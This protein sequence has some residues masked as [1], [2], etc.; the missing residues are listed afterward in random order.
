MN[1]FT[2][3]VLGLEIGATESD[4]KVTN[5]LEGTINMLIEI[6]KQARDNKDFATSDRIR[7]ELI[8][9]G[10]QLKDGKEALLLASNYSHEKPTKNF[11]YFFDSWV[12]SRE[13]LPTSTQLQ[14]QPNLLSLWY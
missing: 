14:V 11:F 6:R 12:S 7:D 1:A 13:F 8:A 3:E 2:Q 5:A 9:L 10:V 4:E